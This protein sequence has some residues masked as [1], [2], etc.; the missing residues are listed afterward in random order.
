MT[1]QNQLVLELA[2]VL[3]G[4]S[5]GMFFAEL[6]ARVIK[7]ENLTTGGDVTRSWKLPTEAADNDRPAYFSSVNWGKESILLDLKQHEAQGIVHQLAEKADF[8]IASYLPGQATKLGVDYEQL[9]AI[10]PSL[11]YGE[12]NGYGDGNPRAAYDAIIQ[13]E[14][15][16]TYLNG[17]TDQT[18][19]M[20]VALMDILAGH[21]LKQAMLLAWIEKMQTGEGKRVSVSLIQSGIASLANQA[22]NWLTAGQI[23]Q[24]MGSEHPNI[25]PYG[26]A[27][28]CSD[29]KQMILAI[30]SDQ[31][32][33]RLRQ[34]LGLADNPEFA[35]NKKRV[36]SREAVN[37]ELQHAIRTFK[38]DELLAQFAQHHIPAGAV[39]D[40]PA[41]FKQPAAS[42]LLMRV[43]SHTGLRS[44]VAMDHP[45]SLT[46]PPS[47]GAHGEKI[48]DELNIS[49][50]V[51]KQLSAKKVIA[52]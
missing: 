40:M 32:Y 42:E 46:P 15:G 20:P 43:D 29:G 39:N 49:I 47:T 23:P 41:V 9:S 5:V 37:E 17:T 44:F 50:S 1:F 19:K 8:V 7:V 28:E 16:F 26:K 13:A 2:N 3:A 6:G 22:S 18:Y 4:P 52:L 31:Q 33:S 14:A 30:G 11:I 51:Q 36:A 34:I 27:F 48:L 12:I 21:Q 10:K 45:V 25:V 35:R 38:R 24:P